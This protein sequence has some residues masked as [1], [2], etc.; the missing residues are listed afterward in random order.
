MIC[1]WD[2]EADEQI[3]L[4]MEDPTAA[5]VDMPK[6]ESHGISANQFVEHGGAIFWAVE[7][8]SME[9]VFVSPQPEKLLGFT[10]EQW[11]GDGSKV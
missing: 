8:P 7:L 1:D 6:S 11:T 10:P 2:D 5:P 4:T 9:F 3:L